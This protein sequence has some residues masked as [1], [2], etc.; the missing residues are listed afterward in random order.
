V[1]ASRA[2]QG[3]QLPLLDFL[4]YVSC[5]YTNAPHLHAIT[6]DNSAAPSHRSH[7]TALRSRV[8]TAPN[9][10]ASM[11]AKQPVQRSSS[12]V[13]TPASL[14]TIAPASHTSIHFGR[15]QCK[16][17]V[18][19]NLPSLYPTESLEIGRGCSDIAVLMSPDWL[20]RRAHASSHVL[21][22]AQ[23]FGIN[24]AINMSNRIPY[25]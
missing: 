6:H 21:H 1:A 22:A 19:C 15:L 5:P 2:P 12:I 23:F 8:N 17:R 13:T 18:R 7:L 16:H 11:Q 24:L 3:P 10:H 20:W 9:G 4:C 25:R 14:F